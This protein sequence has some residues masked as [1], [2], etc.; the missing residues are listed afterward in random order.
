MTARIGNSVLAK[1]TREEPG[2]YLTDEEVREALKESPFLAS[3]IRAMRS[4]QRVEDEV[5]K[6]TVDPVLKKFDF[7]TGRGGYGSAKCYRDVGT[8]YRYCVYA[9]V[10]DDLALLNDKL[11]YWLRTILQSLSF[12][13][14]N[15]SIAAT[16]TLL[17]REMNRRLP[18]ED[19]ALLDP[20]FRAT[21]EILPKK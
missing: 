9:M 3:R 5:V 19:A 6:S 13:G 15:D 8:V 1:I 20:F 14:Y 16:Y 12:P 21:E 11:L 17:R 10:C 2:R 18:A 4:A 7:Q